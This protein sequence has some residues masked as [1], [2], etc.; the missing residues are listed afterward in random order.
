M[1][2]TFILKTTFATRIV[3]PRGDVERREHLP[4]VISFALVPLAPELLQVTAECEETAVMDYFEELTSRIAITFP[5][6]AEEGLETTPKDFPKRP[7]TLEK[8]RKAYAIVVKTR[9][10]FYD[11]WKRGDWDNPTPKM[12]D[13]K[14]ALAYEMGWRPC[15]KTLRRII[16]FGDD[17][18]L[19]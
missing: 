19:G 14:D 15:D 6:P 7:K 11:R 4:P 1:K 3:R 9:K 17:G 5:R 18:L 8:Y 10:R 2:V 16:R 13:H 12:E